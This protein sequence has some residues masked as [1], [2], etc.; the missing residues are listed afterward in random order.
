MNFTRYRSLAI[1]SSVKHSINNLYIPI[2]SETLDFTGL[3][4]HIE[5]AA[6]AGKF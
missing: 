4:V 3:V 5:E 1:G 6:Q 2:P